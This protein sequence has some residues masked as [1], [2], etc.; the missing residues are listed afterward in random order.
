MQDLK[1]T[2][3][4]S[5]KTK[6]VSQIRS[7]TIYLFISTTAGVV[8]AA[9]GFSA[10]FGRRAPGVPLPAGSSNLIVNSTNF[11]TSVLFLFHVYVFLISISVCLSH[12]LL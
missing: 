9:L 4:L 3:I 12:H 2:C 1:I 5:C 6:R 10:A 11:A 7:V 8:T